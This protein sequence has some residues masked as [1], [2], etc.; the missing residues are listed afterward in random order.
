[1]GERTIH[2]AGGCFWGAEAYLAAIPGVVRTRVGYANGTVE[3]PSYQL[4]CTGTTGAA[5]TV[6]VAYDD[7]SLRLDELLA[8][9][10]EVIDPCAVNQQGHDVGT[11]YRTGV[12]WTD[13]ADE[14]VVW[15]ALADLA[16]AHPGDR[17]AVEVAPL[18]SFYPAEDYHQRYLEANPGGYCHIRPGAIAGVADRLA[19]LRAA[20]AG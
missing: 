13:D 10:F 3:T 17:I 16:A 1:M 11:Q 12:Y 2:L 8:L 14:P 5:E 18:T 4:V 15:L 19:A 9:F 7:A 20:A 6:E